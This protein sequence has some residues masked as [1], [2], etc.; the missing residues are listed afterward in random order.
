MSSSCGYI[1]CYRSQSC[2]DNNLLSNVSTVCSECII[3]E[4]VARPLDGCLFV[5]FKTDTGCAD[6]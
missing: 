5:I 3:R 4:H 2:P 6:I 1:R